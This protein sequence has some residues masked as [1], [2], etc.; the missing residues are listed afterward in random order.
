M[1][2]NLLTARDLMSAPVVTVKPELTVADLMDVLLAE[3]LSGV[4]VVDRNQKVVGVVSSTDVMRAAVEE[5]R[6]PTEP[7]ENDGPAAFYREL[8]SAPRALAM[9][10]PANLPRTRLGALP[11][12]E[13]MTRATLSVRPEATLPEVARF[14]DRS[15]VHRALV[16]EGSA[17]VGIVSALDLVRPLTE[18]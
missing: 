14:F 12:R 7:A 16:M 8:G 18:L 2:L 15:G 10:L 4:P 9:T 6:L 3:G 17:L 1:D 5:A 11:V 13:I